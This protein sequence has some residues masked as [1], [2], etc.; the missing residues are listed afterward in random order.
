M[1]SQSH[2]TCV[3]QRSLV[4]NSSNLEV[5]ELEV[6]ERVLVQGLRVRA[7]AGQKGS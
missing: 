3:E 6:A 4:R 2:S 1:A 5:R 7:R